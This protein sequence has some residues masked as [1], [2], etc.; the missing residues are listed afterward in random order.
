MSPVC[1]RVFLSHTS[2][3]GLYPA[4]RTFLKAAET[5]V[6]RAGHAVSGMEYFGAH[7]NRPADVCAD[8]VRDSDILVA[9]VG[10]QYGSLIPDQADVSYTEFEF[11]VASEHGLN[12]LVFLLHEATPIPYYLLDHA[13]HERQSLFRR[14][15]CDD[16]GLVVG[17]FSTPAELEVLLFQALIN[18]G[19]SEQGR[20]DEALDL[21]SALA[22]AHEP[23]PEAVSGSV[24]H[25]LWHE[26]IERLRAVNKGCLPVKPSD[27]VRYLELMTA[28]ARRTIQVVDFVDMQ[29]WLEDRRLRSYLVTQL[30]RNRESP[31]VTVERIR[32]VKKRDLSNSQRLDIL[33]DF[34]R[35]HQEFNAGLL[36]CP[37]RDADKISGREELTFFPRT[38]CILIDAGYPSASYLEVRLNGSGYIRRAQLFLGQ[39]NPM[40]QACEGDFGRLRSAITIGQLNVAVDIEVRA[41]RDSPIPVLF[42]RIPIN[43]DELMGPLGGDSEE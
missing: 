39:T 11:M 18:L 8:E 9:L 14:R 17:T 33:R 3:L 13:N 41:H 36:L 25:G 1:R 23:G 26:S 10:F 21:A 29:Q 40:V 20:F 2:E 42:P 31:P 4:D 43:P 7:D 12:R 32:F 28:G 15:L 37:Y 19:S 34:V 35:L 30:S 38:S 5:A 27:V 24:A 6:T 22:T 16:E